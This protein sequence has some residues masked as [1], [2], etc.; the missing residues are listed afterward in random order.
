MK[1]GELD[2]TPYREIDSASEE[3]ACENIQERGETDVFAGYRR[4]CKAKQSHYSHTIPLKI[5]CIKVFKR[6]KLFLVREDPLAF[7]YQLERV[8]DFFRSV[9]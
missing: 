8:K 7:P 6:I 1:G 3:L 2:E 9:Q 5:L 4:V